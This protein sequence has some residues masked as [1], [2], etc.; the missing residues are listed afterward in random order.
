M[1]PTTIH[2][3]AMQRQAEYRAE[4]DRQRLAALARQGD[5]HDRGDAFASLRRAVDLIIHPLRTTGSSPA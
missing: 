5:T 4:A 3:L 2:Q 1:H